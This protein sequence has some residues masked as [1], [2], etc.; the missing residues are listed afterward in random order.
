VQN[1]QI[2]TFLCGSGYGMRNDAAPCGSGPGFAKLT[3]T[4]KMVIA[5][6]ILLK[7]QLVLLLISGMAKLTNKSALFFV[8]LC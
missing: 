1:S 7:F 6:D 4:R 5:I 8:N 3:N 2:Y